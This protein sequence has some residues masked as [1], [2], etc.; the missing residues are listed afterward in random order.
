MKAHDGRTLSPYSAQVMGGC[1]LCL[2]PLFWILFP[3]SPKSS[4]KKLFCR[5]KKKS[6]CFFSNHWPCSLA[7]SNRI[8]AEPP[9]ATRPVGR[10]ITV[11][12][13]L[14]RC[15]ALLEC[16]T[17]EEM[18]T[19]GKEGGC[20]CFMKCVKKHSNYRSRKFTSP[21][22]TWCA[23][24]RSWNINILMERLI[25]LHTVHAWWVHSL[26]SL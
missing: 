1:R 21:R 3:F 25:L 7:Q 16:D 8:V 26:R 10:E 23:S 15:L 11:S 13:E 2:A 24:E 4:C 19:Q 17:C 22:G 18:P 12:E 20:R 5:W 9:E 6:M 14:A